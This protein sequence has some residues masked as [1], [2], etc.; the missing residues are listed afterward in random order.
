MRWY[1]HLKARLTLARA[2]ELADRRWA[3]NGERYYVMPYGVKLYIICRRE[4]KKMKTAGL[5]NVNAKVRDLD[6]ECFYATPYCDG[7][8]GK[9]NDEILKLKRKQWIDYCDEMHRRKKG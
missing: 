7:V 2:V 5:I 1:R 8:K 3:K 9:Y 6:I 4:F